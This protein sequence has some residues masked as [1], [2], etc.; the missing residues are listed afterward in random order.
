MG[1]VKIP[2][3]DFID[4]IIEKLPAVRD[5]TL[6]ILEAQ[7]LEPDDELLVGVEIRPTPVPTLRPYYC[8]FFFGV[9]RI[10]KKYTTKEVELRYMMTATDTDECFR[11]TITTGK[12]LEIQRTIEKIKELIEPWTRNNTMKFGGNKYKVYIAQPPISYLQT[13]VNEI[14]TTVLFV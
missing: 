14:G 11:G 5:P 10:Y 9:Y 8:T 1:E 3:L 7:F 13:I 12:F 6:E 4:S 2:K